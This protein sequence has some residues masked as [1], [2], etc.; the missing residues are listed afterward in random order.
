MRK[1]NVIIKAFDGDSTDA[2]TLE[3]AFRDIPL[4]TCITIGEAVPW[5]TRIAAEKRIEMRAERVRICEYP[6]VDWN[7]ILPLDEG[8][9]ED[10]RHAEAVVM[11]MVERYARYM[12]RYRIAGDIP[13]HERR[14]QYFA[15]LRYW[16]HV[17]ETER[18]DLFLM[19][20][21]PHQC[22][23]YVLYYLC[24]RKNIPVLYMN[25]FFAMDG[26]YISEN[27]EHPAP[28]LQAAFRRIREEYADPQRPIP[29][30][31]NYEYYFSFYRKKTPEKPWYMEE[32]IY[33]RPNFVRKWWRKGLKV[34]RREPLRF[35]ASM[36]SPAFWSRKLGQHRAI[37]FY[38][39]HTQQ[40]DLSQPYVYVPLHLQP[41]ATTI[42]LAGAF[43]DQERVVQLLAAHLPPGIRL[44]VKEHPA[45]GEEWR[46]EDF[47]K[48]LLSIP[49]VTLIPKEADTYALLDHCIAV[50]SCAGTVLFEAS[51]RQKP[52]FMF[53]HDIWQYGPGV[54][55]I[56]TSQDCRAAVEDILNNRASH[57]VRD[58][59]LYLK[60]F[61]ESATPFPGPTESPVDNATDEEK[62]V[63]VG[64]LL[65]RHIRRVLNLPAPQS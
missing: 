56:R 21:M 8:I 22:Y 53:G 16:N 62:A 41:E 51:I 27:W 54:H 47:Y 29:L 49:S 23:D 24:K 48:T 38:K 14:R 31:K 32:N 6:G 33:T 63:N 12:E 28:D 10:M 2:V 13:Y 58:V 17:L 65:E 50:A 45:Q 46:S 57:S 7:A 64:A 35:T 52:S 15:H 1:P 42:P 44:Y 61:D 34:L 18:I 37:A 5:E 43:V 30:S 36:L 40:P 26:M 9:I 39:Q 11:Q 59:R 20:H 3:R 19:N 4:G 25:R 55:C 60:A